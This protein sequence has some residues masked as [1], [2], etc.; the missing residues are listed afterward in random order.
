M[1]SHCGDIGVIVVTCL[2]LSNFLNCS[3]LFIKSKKT[4]KKNTNHICEIH[5]TTPTGPEHTFHPTIDWHASE[6]CN[7][8]PEIERRDLGPLGSESRVVDTGI[9]F[10]HATGTKPGE[11]EAWG[12]K[13]NT[14]KG[15]LERRGGP[16]TPDDQIQSRDLQTASR[17]RQ[18]LCG[19]WPDHQRPARTRHHPHQGAGKH[20]IKSP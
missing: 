6:K 12:T 13:D 1:G 10:H 4:T 14:N 7:R 8:R 9:R 3:F 20:Q 2:T 18:R 16:G 5:G 17:N 19:V 11:Y 15:S